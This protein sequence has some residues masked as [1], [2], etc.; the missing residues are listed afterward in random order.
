MN[1]LFKWKGSEEARGFIWKP[2]LIY[3]DFNDNKPVFFIQ[4]I[5]MPILLGSY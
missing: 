1:Y 4:Q 3:V 5:G 2:K